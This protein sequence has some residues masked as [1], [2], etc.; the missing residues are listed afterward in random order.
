VLAFS[1]EVGVALEEEDATPRP[2]E[3]SPMDPEHPDLS[4]LVLDQS[5]VPI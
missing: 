1:A 4:T 2:V 3:R 5:L